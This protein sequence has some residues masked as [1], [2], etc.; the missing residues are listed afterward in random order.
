MEGVEPVGSKEY[1]TF[2]NTP[3]S[4]ALYCDYLISYLVTSD[5]ICKWKFFLRQ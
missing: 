2:H 5:L 1:S 3:H 4:E